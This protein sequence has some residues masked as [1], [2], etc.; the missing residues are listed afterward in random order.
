M[1]NILSY[2]G[3]ENQNYFAISSYDLQNVYKYQQ[4]TAHVGQD[5]ERKLIQPLL[6]QWVV[7]QGGEN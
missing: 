7:P 6:N 5:A 1:F 2:Q 4:M 3:N